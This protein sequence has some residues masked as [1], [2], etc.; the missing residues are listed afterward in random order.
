MSNLPAKPKTA[1]ERLQALARAASNDTLLKY[2]SGIWTISDIAVPPTTRFVLYPDQVSHYW[3]HFAGG[4]VVTEITEIVAD[5]DE[6]DVELQIVKGNGREDLGYRDQTKWE[7]DSSGN[8]R[9]PWV[10]G[11][12]LPMMNAE[13]GAV[14]AFKIASVGGMGAVAGQVASYTRNRHLGYPIVTLST[15][16]YKNKKYGGYTSYPVFVSAGYDT[17]P[18]AV[19]ANH[20]PVDGGADAKVIGSSKAP[21]PAAAAAREDPISTGPAKSAGYLRKDM[22]D[23]IPFAPEVR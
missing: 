2:N 14:V 9:D 13:T 18:A 3:T 5:D 20:G 6:G 8:P 12:A 11:F 15:G 21:P 4:K 19:I 22:D 23:D 7:R 1:E 10:Y 16:S 17:P